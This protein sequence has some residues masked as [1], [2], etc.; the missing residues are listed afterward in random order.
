MNVNEVQKRLL[1]GRGAPS[2]SRDARN[3]VLKRGL[4]NQ[5]WRHRW[6]RWCRF[7]EATP[8]LRDRMED[9]I[10]PILRTVFVLRR[11]YGSCGGAASRTE[12]SK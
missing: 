2:C 9:S 11:F 7:V 3:A 8:S 1:G 6:T 4:V 10:R 5:K 12:G